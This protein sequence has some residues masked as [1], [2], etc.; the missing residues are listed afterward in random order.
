MSH[1]EAL[2]AVV[3]WGLHRLLTV[4]TLCNLCRAQATYVNV[5]F[6]H[7][8]RWSRSCHR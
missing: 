3:T 7:P 2:A 4:C 8:G 1:A 6:A 5:G